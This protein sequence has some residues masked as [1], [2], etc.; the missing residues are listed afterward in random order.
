[1]RRYHLWEFFE[2]GAFGDDHEDRNEIAAVARHR[3]ARLLNQEVRG[4][5]ILVIGDTPLDIACG[6]T[7][8][9]KILAVA[10]GGSTLAELESHRPTWA[11]T[12]LEQIRAREICR[13]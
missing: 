8:G 3:G 10:T 2:T 7:I 12:D 9:A 6:R 4:D 11:V 5:E 13:S 1:M